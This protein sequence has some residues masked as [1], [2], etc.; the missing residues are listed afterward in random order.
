MSNAVVAAITELAPSFAGRLIPPSDLS[1][2]TARMVHNGLIDKHP[3]LV[4]Q[5]RG[6]ADIVDAVRLGRRLGLEIAVRGGGHNVAGRGTSDGGL[7][8]DLSLMK[9]IHVDPKQRTAR[10]EGGALWRD[11]NRETQVYGLATTGGV[12]GSTGVAGLTLGGGLGWL[13]SK[14]GMALD[15]LIS[16]DLVLADGKVVRASEDENPDL[17]WAVRGGGGNFGVAA[18]FEFRLH[19]VGPMV[20]AGLVAHPVARAREVLHFFRTVTA[21]VPDDMMLFGGLL[22]AEDGVTKIAAMIG[23]HF[24]P[25]SE[26]EAAMR[27]VK[28]FG[29]PIL[30]AI[31]PMPF[32]TFATMLDGGF[33]RGARN[34][35]KSH[36][37][38]QLTDDAIDAIVERFEHCPSPMS[39]I[40]L[41]HFH[42]A[43]TRVPATATAY[44]LRSPGYN[45][46]VL[47]Q[48]KESSDDGRGLAWGRESYAAFQPFVGQKRYLNYLG[49]D[50]GDQALTAAYGPNL[51]R[52][53]ELKKKFDPEN[54]FRVNVNIRP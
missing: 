23:V 6:I 17:F 34:Y 31:G 1:F 19:P 20:T 12:I 47:S 5:C 46:V 4:A 38:E 25:T 39:A 50:E 18:S 24:G 16:V 54:V 9:G 26:A 33:P 48:W 15:N 8:I 51:S 40:L 37:M 13:M 32:S 35:W 14:H 49:D 53:R 43:V 45:L 10:A 27:P 7:V 11:F 42:G 52:L 44:A 21:S 41:E 28:A 30:D 2:N 36:F 22:T 29:Q 3:A